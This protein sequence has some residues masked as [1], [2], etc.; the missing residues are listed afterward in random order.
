MWASY[1]GTKK[2]PHEAGCVVLPHKGAVSAQR[3]IKEDYGGS[4]TGLSISSA[5]L[6]T[7][8]SVP[9]PMPSI[10]LE[11]RAVK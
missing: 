8:I 11:M 10:R 4:K 9:P 1:L 2:N 3:A 7:A 6:V 5:T